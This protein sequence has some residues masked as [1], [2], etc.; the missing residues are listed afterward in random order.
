MYDRAVT[1]DT[2]F[3]KNPSMQN[4]LAMTNF[5]TEALCSNS[6]KNKRESNVKK[7]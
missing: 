2:C 3:I 5:L 7:R 1:S 6:K 4:T